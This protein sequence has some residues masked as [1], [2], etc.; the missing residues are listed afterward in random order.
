MNVMAQGNTSY[1]E[2]SPT[3]ERHKY[4]ILLC[5]R[6]LLPILDYDYFCIPD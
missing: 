6:V 3:L 5:Q 1:S 4:R 2:K